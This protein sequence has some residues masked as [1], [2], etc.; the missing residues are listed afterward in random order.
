[1]PAQDADAGRPACPAGHFVHY[2]NPALT[3]FAFVE[4][5]GRFLVLRRAQEP[6]RGEWDLPGGF[7]E[8][9][10]SPADCVRREIAEET[11]LEVDR[12]AVFGA[13]TSRYGE[14]G[15]WTVDIAYRCRASGGHVRL[16]AEKSEFAWTGLGNLPR[17]AFDG[18][19][20]ALAAFRSLDDGSRAPADPSELVTSTR[21]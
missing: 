7:I 21:L 2:D 15:K 4:R 9:G 16:S 10:E 5:D 1:M 13:Y 14:D 3:A 20:S 11:G 8:A 19:R 17:L 18:E 12:L 6:E